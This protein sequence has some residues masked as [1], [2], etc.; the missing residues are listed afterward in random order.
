MEG[1]DPFNLLSLSCQ[2]C[3]S[4]LLFGLAWELMHLIT[5]MGENSVVDSAADEYGDDEIIS[6]GF[7][8]VDLNCKR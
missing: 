1:N 4:A 6:P 7:K 2:V 8:I 5:S 3:G